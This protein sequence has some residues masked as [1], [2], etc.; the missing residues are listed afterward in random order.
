MT[1]KNEVQD[2]SAKV[3]DP[4]TAAIA[5]EESA[6]RYMLAAVLAVVLVII[7]LTG[8][9]PSSSYNYAAVAGY[10][11]RDSDSEMFKTLR[12]SIELQTVLLLAGIAVAAV[13]WRTTA[14]RK[15][16]MAGFGIV[17]VLAV[18]LLIFRSVSAL[19]LD[20]FFAILTLL[21]IIVAA[22]SLAC[23]IRFFNVRNDKIT[24]VIFVIMS[25]LFAMAGFGSATVAFKA[26][27]GADAQA[28]LDEMNGIAEGAGGNAPA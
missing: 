27:T 20:Y 2:V 10:C 1:S 9:N 15:I 7:V 17:G 13:F 21:Y 6:Y 16:G 24:G 26:V 11:L 12:V 8:A 22:I 14:S 25:V 19:H 23:A 28:V 3:V 5:M 4:A 18:V